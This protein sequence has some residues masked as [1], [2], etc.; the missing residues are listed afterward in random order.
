MARTSVTPD[1]ASILEFDAVG[2][3]MPRTVRRGGGGRRHR[4]RRMAGETRRQEV[5]RLQDAT[6]AVGE[7]ESVAIMGSRGSGREELLRLA[8]GT[9][10][11]DQGRVRRRVPIVPM[12]EVAKALSRSMTFRHNIYLVGGLLGMT[13]DAVSR[14]LGD[15][16][17]FAGVESTLDKY[18]GSAPPVVRQRL[19]WSIATSTDARAFA[20]DEVLVVGER[21]FRQECWTRLDRMRADGVTFL[22]SSDSYKQFRRFC[23]RAIVLGEGTVRADTSVREGIAVLRSLRGRGVDAVAADDESADEDLRDDL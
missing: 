6:F 5:W 20:I 23:D 2:I 8:A 15:I 21:E 14:R 16:A 22:V 11:P 17:S 13:P 3:R 12:V 9:L 10:I 7:G 4:L 19:A 1:L 18:L